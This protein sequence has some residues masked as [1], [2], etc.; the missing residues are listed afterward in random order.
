MVTEKELFKELF[1]N[2]ENFENGK[3]SYRE[4]KSVNSSIFE[5]IKDEYSN[6]KSAEALITQIRI[7]ANLILKE[8]RLKR[9]LENEKMELPKGDWHNWVIPK[10]ILDFGKGALIINSFNKK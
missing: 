9:N 4:A 8:A 7:S 5:R 3:I 10:N 6:T 2:V 1:D